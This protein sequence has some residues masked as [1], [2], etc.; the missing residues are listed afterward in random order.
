MENGRG[1]KKHTRV[2]QFKKKVSVFRDTEISLP[3]RFIDS[4]T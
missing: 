3:G 2:F 1:R 4:D